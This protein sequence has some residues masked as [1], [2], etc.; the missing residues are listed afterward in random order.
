MQSVAEA[1]ARQS[2]TPSSIVEPL[3]ASAVTSDYMI[4][5]R[6]GTVV[7][8]EPSKIAVAVTKAFIAVEGTH[9]AESAR[10]RDL[11]A[12]L[13]DAVVR[14]LQ[15]RQPHGGTFHIEDIQ[16]QVE[17]ALMRSGEHDVAKA[18]V[19]YREEKGCRARIPAS[20][21][22][23][24]CAGSACFWIVVSGRPL[25]LAALRRLVESACAGLGEHVSADAILDGALRNLYDGVP[26]E[27]LRKA[28]IL[29]ARTQN[30]E[31]S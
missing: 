8:F 14:A 19:L 18:Y 23:D 12:Q 29:A 2:F 9:G 20:S 31:G 26:V 16:D 11:V 22:S 10:V 24:G 13:T 25:D 21:E 6:N 28:L 15:R 5:R 17:L 7:T 4:I 30:R 1:S 3:N 27:E